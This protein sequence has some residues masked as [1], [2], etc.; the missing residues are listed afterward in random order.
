MSECVIDPK[1]L[2]TGRCLALPGMIRGIIET[3]ASF[4]AT[5]AQIA[6]QTFWQAAITDSANTR[7]WL[8]PLFSD[9]PE[10]RKTETVYEE[11]P[12]SYDKVIDGRYR[13]LGKISKSLCFHKA[14][15]THNGKGNRLWLLVTSKTSGMNI[16]GTYVGD[17]ESDVA[18]YSGFTAD[19]VNVEN[20]EFN[21]GSV[22][23]K[24]PIVIA[25][26][27][28][29]EVNHDVYGA[30]MFAAQFIKLLSPLTDVTLEVVG[31]PT[32][33]E[34]VVD[35]SVTCDETPVTGLVAADFSVLTTAGVTQLISTV[36]ESS[37]VPGRYTIT[38]ASGSYVDGTVDLVGP[39]D[40]SIYPDSAYETVAAADVN[41]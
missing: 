38:R 30:F 19:L 31:T 35:V 6:D 3:P 11:N 20:L 32:T 7:I 40:L 27:D 8:W 22:S 33:T 18:Q 13:W 16:I 28:P 23:S 29:S 15:F 26:E 36:A 10:D 41:V 17:N 1:N 37:T 39:Q 21:N 12:V 14:A 5:A 24:T 25:L 34:I 2:G 4:K 9:I